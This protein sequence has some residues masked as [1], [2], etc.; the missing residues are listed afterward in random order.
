MK[1]ERGEPAPFPFLITREQM[2]ADAKIWG[3]E[4]WHY[5]MMNEAK[6]PRGQGSRRVLTRQACNKFGAFKEPN[7][8]D[9][10]RT[11]IAFLDA[12]YRGVGG[13]RCVFGEL[14]FGFEVEPLD[15]SV[16]PAT[17]IS[18]NPTLKDGRQI[19]ALIDLVTVPIN[20]MQGAD[21]P[22]DQ[23]VNF[24]MQQCLARGIDP[25]NFY[26]DSGMR[27][28]LVTAFARLWSN[29]INSIDCGG[30]ASEKPVSSE[31]QTLCRDYYSKFVTE[32]WF[33]VR[34]AVES[35]QFRGMSEDLCTEF[36]QREWKM[37]S[38][39]RI[40]VEAKEE[41]K[42]KS[43]RSP[44]LAD[45][46]AVGL[47]GA[48]QRGFMITKLSSLAPIKHGP[49]WRK[50]FKEKARKLSKNGLLNHSA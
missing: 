42:Q 35:Q 2:E 39:N 11:K 33:S 23:I 3:V 30:K 50:G 31:I 19:I 40:E 9:S 8:R 46:V 34:M 44:D 1:V 14:Q 47:F 45:A 17:I 43:G 15:A 28:S 16:L 13:D 36:C 27:T 24:V 25:S 4:D 29:E 26:F 32:L 21:T 41:M 10:R 5:T 18:Q 49:D 7:W 20:S 12:A 22:E 38:G 37:V 48:R 6:M